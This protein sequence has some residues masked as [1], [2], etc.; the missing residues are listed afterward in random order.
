MFRR[1]LNAFIKRN[2]NIIIELAKKIGILIII[3]FIGTVI[4][5]NLINKE[6]NTHETDDNISIYNPSK[7]VI[8]GNNITKEN[9]NQD[10]EII[11]KFVDYCNNKDVN[12][13]YNLLSKDCRECLYGTLEKFKIGYYEKIFTNKKEFNLQSWVNNE[14]YHTYRIRYM[15]DFLSSGDYDD[16]KKGED[17]ITIDNSENEMKINVNGFICSEFINKEIESNGIEINISKR[18]IFMNYEEYLIKVKNGTKS[19]IIIDTGEKSNSIELFDNSNVKYSARKMNI[20]NLNSELL[21]NITRPLKI[22]FDKNYNPKIKSKYIEFTDIVNDI[23]NYNNKG[24][25][26]LSIKIDL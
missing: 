10:E 1:W 3:V 23:K 5:S 8:T 7:T 24:K 6:I 16:I 22:R 9:Y 4:M 13:A 14:N 25:N 17:Y 11:Q 19:N 18:N 12:S 20:Q 2:K 15:D 21:V 26:R